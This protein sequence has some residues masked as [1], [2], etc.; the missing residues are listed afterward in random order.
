[1]IFIIANKTVLITHK[2][3]CGLLVVRTK[4]FNCTPSWLENKYRK[5]VDVAAVSINVINLQAGLPTA[6]A[7]TYLRLRKKTSYERKLFIVPKM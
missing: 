6:K 1:M 4:P 2:Q 3:R 7:Y 5:H